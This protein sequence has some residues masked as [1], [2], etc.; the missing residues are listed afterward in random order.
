M[1]EV[2][3]CL[4]VLFGRFYR[5]EGTQVPALI[6]FWILLPRIDAELAGF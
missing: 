1:F 2:L 6:R 3:N 5:G 4:F